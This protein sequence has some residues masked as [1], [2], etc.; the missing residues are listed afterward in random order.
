MIVAKVLIKGS[1][2]NVTFSYANCEKR[3][4]QHDK[5]LSHLMVDGEESLKFYADAGGSKVDFA[6]SFYNFLKLDQKQKKFRTAKKM[7]Q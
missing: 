2:R 4:E 5:A 6:I 3:Y 7:V 1:G